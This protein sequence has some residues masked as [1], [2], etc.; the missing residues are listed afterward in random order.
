M[1]T[2]HKF[3]WL[4]KLQNMTREEAA[5]IRD[6]RLQLALESGP[7]TLL[8]GEQ[9]EELRSDKS[10]ETMT[11]MGAPR[12]QRNRVPKQA[13][14][15]RVFEE[16]RQRDE[17][18]AVAHQ[19]ETALKLGI[20]M[21][22]VESTEIS[23]Q[24]TSLQ[25]RPSSSAGNGRLQARSKSSHSAAQSELSEISVVSAPAR[26]NERRCFLPRTRFR[27]TSG[28][29]LTAS[30]LP[31]VGGSRLL[32]PDG[33]MCVVLRRTMLP[34]QEWDFVQ[35]TVKTSLWQHHFIVTA[36]HRLMR[37]G[38]RGEL[39]SVQASELLRAQRG[40]CHIVTGGGP[41]E[42]VA[43]EMWKESTAVVEVVFEG[44]ATVLA[45]TPPKRRWRP[46]SLSPRTGIICSGSPPDVSDLMHDAGVHSK[47]GLLATGIQGNARRRCLSQ[48]DDPISPLWMS[49]GSKSHRLADL[50]KCKVCVQHM[51]H[52]EK[53]SAPACNRGEACS[54]CHMPH[55]FDHVV[56]GTHFGEKCSQIHVAHLIKNMAA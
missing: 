6:A 34:K 43:A 22:L 24:T 48:G 46:R 37:Q 27:T 3:G 42:V 25:W 49:E 53:P 10:S 17:E 2:L 38:A 47:H 9:L 41:A 44:D 40:K 11:Q 30:N 4:G 33:K 36:D 39:I 15:A 50:G 32:G 21:S 14:I 13:S 51:R 29:T 28:T 5:R 45:W 26:L 56:Q 19:N 12:E 16:G 52:L 31:A 7:E 35:L 18:L 23:A 54:R 20:Q 8:E 55:H 1:A